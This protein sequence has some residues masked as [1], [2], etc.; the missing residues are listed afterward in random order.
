MAD[1]LR[2][3][4]IDDDS[5]KNVQPLRRDDIIFAV[6][7]QL[8]DGFEGFQQLR[9]NTADDTN[10]IS[11]V[12]AGD[13]LNFRIPKGEPLGVTV[14]PR[15]YDG[16]LIKLRNES[17]EAAYIEEASQ[18]LLAERLESDRSLHKRAIHVLL[19][20]FALIVFGYW[21][22]GYLIE[23][24]YTIHYRG[25]F[26]IVLILIILPIAYLIQGKRGLK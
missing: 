23:S 13:L 19:Y 17:R 6:D 12:R 1:A 7:S 8:F 14:T 22:N 25:G 15:V 16:N 26:G 5:R 20:Y 2:V 18:K 21:F 11:I 3:N 10:Q 24:G 4:W 9:K